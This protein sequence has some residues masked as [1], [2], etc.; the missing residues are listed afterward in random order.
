MDDHYAA[1]RVSLKMIDMRKPS[2]LPPKPHGSPSEVSKAVR[3]AGRAWS[4]KI[5]RNRDKDPLNI[6]TAYINIL[7]VYQCVSAYHIHSLYIYL[8]IHVYLQLYTY[9]WYMDIQDMIYYYAAAGAYTHNTGLTLS[10]HCFW[11]WTCGCSCRTL[12]SD[13]RAGRSMSPRRGGDSLPTG[14]SDWTDGDPI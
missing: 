14:R 12:L 3:L 1:L 2:N 7:C 5:S 10:N 11:S 8:Y 4:F 9:I 6:C 13:A